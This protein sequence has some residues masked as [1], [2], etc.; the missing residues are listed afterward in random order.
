MD[1]STIKTPKDVL[2]FVRTN[3]KYG[4]LDY[5]GKEHVGDMIGFRASY[6][7]SSLEEVLEHKMGSCIEQTYLMKYLLDRLDI[8]SRMFCIREYE[9]DNNAARYNVYMH[10]FILYFLNGKVYH[11]ENCNLKKLGIHE[12]D[13]YEEAISSIS[14]LFIMVSDGRWS[15]V[16]EFFDVPYGMSFRELN[17]YMNSLDI[18]KSNV[19]VR[20]RI[21]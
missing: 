19:R 2:E 20:K 15:T 21:V 5:M 11:I 1:F 18:D 7:T 9:A 16:T 12:F 17:N 13:S 6:R 3:I 14:N 8:P 4:W 10:C